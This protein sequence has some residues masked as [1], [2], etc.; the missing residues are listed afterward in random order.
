MRVKGIY[1][2]TNI[3]NGVMY[4][5]SSISI[6]NRF[7][8]HLR[9]LRNNTHSN[10][11]LQNSV[12]KYGIENFTFSILS[13]QPDLSREDLLELEELILNSYDKEQLFNLTFQTNG[14][15]AD[16]VSIP[17]YLLDLEGNIV[18]EFVSTREC[19]TY[20]GLKPAYKYLNTSAKKKGLYRIVTKEFYENNL[21]LIKS[22]KPLIKEV[23]IK[24]KIK[25][26]DTMTG[27]VSIYQTLKETG[28]ML[29]ISAERVRQCLHN[30]KLLS[31]RYL[32]EHIS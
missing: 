14:G 19:F 1:K 2:I 3:I 10:Q 25:V 17:T 6:E 15:G 24:P 30:G 7:K 5:G 12:N 28:L 23:K 21:E 16:A 8:I 18:K 32:I 31:K 26:K 27:N 11:K 20:I 4:I 13:Y 29:N 9:R 22:W